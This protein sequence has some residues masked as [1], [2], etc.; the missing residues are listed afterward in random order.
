MMKT[1]HIFLDIIELPRLPILN[2][3][4]TIGVHHPTGL[5]FR[6]ATVGK[7]NEDTFYPFLILDFSI[8]FLYQA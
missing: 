2:G 3:F 7:R 5:Y 6:H 1:M 8:L 4:L